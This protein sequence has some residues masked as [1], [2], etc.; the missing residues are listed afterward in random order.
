MKIEDYVLSDNAVDLDDV[1]LDNLEEWEKQ[2]ILK[3]QTA[4]KVFWKNKYVWLNYKT[5]K[6][7]Q[8]QRDKSNDEQ[9][10]KQFPLFRI[11]SF[12]FS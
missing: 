3:V 5:S 6:N 2:S 4:T 10:I 12:R 9:F 7:K 8:F 1:D 11:L